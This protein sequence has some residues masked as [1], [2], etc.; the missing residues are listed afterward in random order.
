MTKARPKTA[1]IESHCPAV[2]G[3][4]RFSHEAMA[5]T[6]EVIVVHEDERYG[7]Q[8]AVA[9]FDE[10]DKLEAELSRFVENS[11]ISQINNLPVGRSLVLGLAAFECLKISRWVFDETKGAFDITIGSLLKCWR[12]DDG[13]PRTPTDEQLALARAR[14]GTNLLKLNEDEHT[15]EVLAEGVQVDLGGIGKGYA[16]DQ[17]AKLLREWSIDVA[18]IHGG[19][20]SVLALDGPANMK[21]WPVSVSHPGKDRRVLAKLDLKGRALSGSGLQKGG[22]IIDPRTARAARA[23]LAAWSLTTDA[24][25]GDALSTAFMVMAPGEI[26]E[27]CRRHKNAAAMVI[28]EGKDEPKGEILRFGRW[29]EGVLL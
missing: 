15:V 14:T 7:Q 3:M 23:K 18:L 25:T 28:L 19:Y 1:Y 5:T 22:H 17:M 20:S 24:A 12:D 21:G 27:F 8:A 26:E 13:R 9:A 10:V 2:P 29:G 4:K 6:Y 16:V 11:D